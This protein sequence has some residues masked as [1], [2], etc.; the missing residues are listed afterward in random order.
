MKATTTDLTDPR[1][2]REM[3][4]VPVGEREVYAVLTEEER[5]KGFVRPLRDTYV[6]AGRRGGC[7]NKTVI[8]DRAI[9]E[10]MARDPGFYQGGYCWHCRKH[11]PNEEF[12][13]LDGT[14]VGT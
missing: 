3:D 7:G 6:H 8:R 11:R 14:Q 12:E 1:I 13:W 2:K 9:V 5:A 10:T 4:F